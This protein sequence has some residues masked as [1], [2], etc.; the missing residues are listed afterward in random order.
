MRN[1]S[2]IVPDQYDPGVIS[3]QTNMTP[4]SSRSREGHIGLG[5]K[6]RTRGFLAVITAPKALIVFCAGRAM[7][8]KVFRLP[9]E[10]NRRTR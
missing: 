1:I 6:K 7:S 8:M 4:G 2:V 5:K 3:V 10:T 9:N